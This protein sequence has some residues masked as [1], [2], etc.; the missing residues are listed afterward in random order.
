[1]KF[2][3]SIIIPC[4]NS[5]KYIHKCIDSLINQTIGINNLELIFVNDASTD[6]TLEILKNYEVQYPNNILVVD[7]IENGRQGTARNIGMQYATSDYIAFVDS[8]DYVDPDMY[9]ILYEKIISYNCDCVSC[10]CVIEDI[11]GSTITTK[12]P[13]VYDTLINTTNLED[14][15]NYFLKNLITGVWSCI[16]KKSIIT[17]N[18]ILF[19]EKLTYED[20]YWN[21]IIYLYVNTHYCC[22]KCLY[23]YV[24]HQNSTTTSTNSSH[25]LDRLTIELLKL[26]K[27]KELGVFDLLHDEIE[28]DFLGMFYLNTLNILFTRFSDIPFDTIKFIQN[29]VLELFP[30]FED[31]KLFADDPTLFNPILKTIRYDWDI[32]QWREFS[33]LYK[34]TYCN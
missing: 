18:N 13:C 27:Y 32:N 21:S 14:K 30:N 15:R 6:S 29:K 2:K 11:Y 7:C 26:N 25:H 23:H 4:Y 24:L 1:M 19:P 31:N 33:K 5:E 8:D 16:Y 28:M 22:S 20:N 10:G 3:L 34:E 17:Q 9:K 12:L